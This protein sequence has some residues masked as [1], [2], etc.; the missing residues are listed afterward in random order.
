MSL[1]PHQQLAL[2][3]WLL[4]GAIC[5]VW[6]APWRPTR[7]VRHPTVGCLLMPVIPL[8]GLGPLILLLLLCDLPLSR[9]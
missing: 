6:L 3:A 8:V 9:R 7:S 1:T 5:Y 2:A 4:C